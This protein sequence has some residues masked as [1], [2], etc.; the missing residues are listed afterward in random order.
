MR[1]RGLRTFPTVAGGRLGKSRR[2]SS[3]TL[4]WPWPAS[5]G[6]SGGGRARPRGGV[7]QKKH[8]ANPLS[9][10]RTGSRNVGTQSFRKNAR[11]GSRARRGFRAGKTRERRMDERLGSRGTSVPRRASRPSSKQKKRGKGTHVV[12]V[13]VVVRFLVIHRSLVRGHLA[14]HRG[15]HVPRPLS[16]RGVSPGS[17]L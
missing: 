6:R 5:R 10:I 9:R 1:S 11:D 7:G 13:D 12:V 8:E 4:S 2:W 15:R 3:W 16:R 17:D 14:L